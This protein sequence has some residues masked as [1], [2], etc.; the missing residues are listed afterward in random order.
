MPVTY[1][2]HDV[3][4]WEYCHG[5]PIDMLSMNHIVY[6]SI[7]VRGGS[8]PVI[9]PS[10]KSLTSLTTLEMC[11][12]FIVGITDYPDT[13]LVMYVKNTKITDLGKLPPLLEG[14]KAHYNANMR[15]PDLPSSVT[16]IEV[17]KQPIGVLRVGPSIIHLRLYQ[18]KMDRIVGL[19]FNSNMSVIDISM[20]SSPYPS[21]LIN[22]FMGLVVDDTH[23]IH[24]VKMINDINH[25]NS[26]RLCANLNNIHS[27]S[28]SYVDPNPPLS[29]RVF[30][31]GSN[32]ARRM[33]EFVSH[34]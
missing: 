24:I 28:I 2:S 23:F 4:C 10:L 33:H 20:C 6:L 15:F 30:M 31:N 18:C 1:I 27:E 14:F 19:A 12:E 11:S 32:Y 3:V 16:A 26:V 17:F 29:V 8:R 9:I 25:Q 5:E 21:I 34:L 7:T 13:L 22:K